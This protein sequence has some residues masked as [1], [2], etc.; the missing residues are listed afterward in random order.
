LK[1]YQARLGGAFFLSENESCLQ[2]L[3]RNLPNGLVGEGIEVQMLIHKL[4]RSVLAIVLLCIVGCGGGS[5]SGSG[6]NSNWKYVAMGDSL[7]V[8]LIAQQG[9]V[10]RYANYTEIDNT[11]TVSVQNLGVSGWQSAD[12]LNALRNDT[13]FRNAVSAAQV[14]TWD[15][16]GND[17]AHAFRQFVNGDCGGVDQQQCF[18]DAVA[19]FEANWDAIVSELRSL[20][21]PGK[22]IFRTMDIYNPFVAEQNALGV[23]DQTTVYLDQVNAHI[24]QSAQLNGI[25]MAKV[26]EAFNGASGREDP[27]GKGLL[28]ADLFHANDNGH[29]VMA[30]AMRV[31][32]YAPTR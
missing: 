28:A 15:I 23:F 18:R 5:T 25:F 21:D 30:D 13:N 7:A 10:Q 6:S 8:G 9:Y 20:N 31:L 1:P 12:L 19:N 11:V 16:G 29:K 22:N 17:L 3:S 24:Q 14:I 27:I 32:G 4:L 26:H 2:S